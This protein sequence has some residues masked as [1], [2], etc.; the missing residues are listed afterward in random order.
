MY[1]SDDANERRTQAARSAATRRTLIDAARAL[2]AARGYAETSTEEIVRRAHVTRGALYHHFTDK[3]DLFR[4]VIEEIERDIDDA[5]RVAAHGTANAADAFVAGSGAF[6][7]ACL[8]PDV[9][10]VL[11]LDGPAVLGWQEWHSIE[12]RHALA[13]VEQGLQALVESG[14]L[15]PQPVAPLA[16]LVHGALIEAGLVIAAAGDP[17]AARAELGASLNR[18]LG[19]PGGATTSVRHAADNRSGSPSTADTG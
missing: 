15:A 2:F 17:D 3:Q 5:V 4:A 9:K 18:L 13:Q 16:H 11:L 19:L 14:Y 8:L 12:V 7:D 10:Q 6:L 1:V